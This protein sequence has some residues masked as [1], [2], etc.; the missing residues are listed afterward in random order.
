MLKASNE[1]YKYQKN[2]WRVNVEKE[3]EEKFN[4]DWE[5]V[6]T[7]IGKDIPRYYSI[8]EIIDLRTGL[9]YVGENET[10][11]NLFLFLG[12]AFELS[13]VCLDILFLLF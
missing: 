3:V 5:K 2:R 9:H 11:T 10:L 13:E 1:K 6:S 12:T 4:R 7:Q 8:C